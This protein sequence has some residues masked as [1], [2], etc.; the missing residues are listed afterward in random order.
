MSEQDAFADFCALAGRDAEDPALMAWFAA[1]LSVPRA[2][3]EFLARAFTWRRHVEPIARL[4]R[5][6][7]PE[8]LR[9][10][11]LVSH[12]STACLQHLL[13]L[14]R[15]RKGH[16]DEVAQAR[17]YMRDVVWRE[18]ALSTLESATADEFASQMF[19]STD[20]LIAVL[21]ALRDPIEGA[22][23]EDISELFPELHALARAE[24]ITAAFE[25]EASV[26]EP[27]PLLEHLVDRTLARKLRGLEV[28]S[29][30]IFQ[31]DDALSLQAFEADR[32]TL[33]R[34]VEHDLASVLRVVLA[35]L[36]FSKGGTDSARHQWSKRGADLSVHNEASAQILEATGR[37]RNVE[38]LR[39]QPILERFTL[40]M[41]RHHG[42]IGQT[43][44]GETPLLAFESLIE[45]LRHER[46]AL[47]EVFG[48]SPGEAIDLCLDLYHLVNA[49]DTAG[50]RE[51][52][53]TDRLRFEMSAVENLLGR[54]ARQNTDTAAR[55]AL[56]S[57]E[58]D[59]TSAESER[60]LRRI[61][62]QWLF[63]KLSRLRTQRRRDGEPAEKLVRALKTL[64]SGTLES[65]VTGLDRVTLWYCESATS[66]FSIIGQL[67]LIALCINSAAKAGIEVDDSFHITFAPLVEAFAGL[68]DN[69]RPY[70]QRL[71]E[72]LL[73]E[74]NINDVFTEDLTLS[75]VCNALGSF[76][77]QIG[78]SPA[79][80]IEIRESEEARA[81][82]TLLPAYE[83]KSS[84]EFHKVLKSICDLYDLRKDEYDRVSNEAL[85]LAT[86]NSAR[87]DKARML[88]WI[89]PGK[90]VEI[91][92]G[93]GIVL[94]LISEAFPDSSVIGIDASA[95]VVSALRQ[96]RSDE[97]AGWDIVEGDAF[98]LS[99]H[100]EAGTVSTVVLCS[101]LHEIY[102]Y[103][104]VEVSEEVRR[105][106][107][108]SVRDL[109]RE[110][111]AV[112]EPGGR[113]VIRDGVM[114]P[115]EPRIVEFLDPEGPEFFELFRD[116]FPGRPIRGEWL[117]ATRLMLNAPDAM[118]FLY[119]Y[120]WGPQSFPYEVREQYGVLPY[121]EYA[122][123]ILS[124][125][126]GDPEPHMVE[127]PADLKGY[128]QDGYCQGLADKVH[129][130]DANG[131]PVQLP[132]S[133]ALWV[134]EKGHRKGKD[135]DS[136]A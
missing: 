120:T 70:R 114:P 65:I 17:D 75:D 9:Q 59:E 118:E 19:A 117:D 54:L 99:S 57:F 80:A 6:T 27:L 42:L 10:R 110:C 102:S 44:R 23:L 26:S 29:I 100:V 61:R 62:E 43:I 71:F 52:L 130:M 16:V 28:A 84:A 24:G 81:L 8:E 93:G 136:N 83:R 50:V 3:L 35:F 135:G 103:R 77:L 5:A 22:Y 92:P 133:N 64:D 12:Q 63:D 7:W 123:S 47:A 89:R 51:G 116:E 108:E 58:R 2:E 1:A 68:D 21:E 119:C 124:W 105:F 87:D 67:K 48:V 104:Q 37:L 72:A 78:H 76:S 20:V 121:D 106:R 49:L 14:H 122:E 113:I 97:H 96:R 98:E 88:E 73:S 56:T 107:L 40:E 91:G 53:Y 94:D 13:E 45:Y 86:M 129:L 134:V 109:L 79:I 46:D 55:E 69:A 18:H 39:D 11:G 128:L 126:R 15:V 111:Y 32:T 25:H 31:H 95:E 82:F 115:D 38:I 125:L 90:I 36:D 85:Y 41:I 34:I 4:V 30:A 101:V 66:S 112:L 131:K 74:I 33:S 127:I 132:D 60:D